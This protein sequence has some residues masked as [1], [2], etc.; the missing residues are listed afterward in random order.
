V[1][2]SQAAQSLTYDQDLMNIYTS[3]PQKA[4]PRFKFVTH[5]YGN[6]ER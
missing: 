6:T 5:V 2:S 3:G 4:G 1:Y